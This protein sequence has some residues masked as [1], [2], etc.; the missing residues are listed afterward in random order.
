MYIRHY[1][2]KSFS[3]SRFFYFFLFLPP[4]HIRRAHL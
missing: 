1:D 3:R 4:P 2:R